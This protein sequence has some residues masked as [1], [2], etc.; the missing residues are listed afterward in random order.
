MNPRIEGIDEAGYFRVQ[1]GIEAAV[2]RG[3]FRSGLEHYLI[4]H[5]QFRSTGMLRGFDETGYLAANPDVAT[6]VARGEMKSGEQ[7]FILHGAAERRAG[8]GL[9]YPFSSRSL[10]GYLGPA[11]NPP[12]PLRVRVSNDADLVQF[13]RLGQIVAFDL[14]SALERHGSLAP[15]AR[16][17]D[18]G[19]GCGRVAQYFQRLYPEAELHGTDIDREAIAWAR[20]TLA[21]V[22]QFASNPPLPP[23]G[24]P[25][26]FFDAIYS[27][28][29]FTHLPEEFE[30][31]WVAE[32]ARV[33]KPGGLLLFTTHGPGLLDA[34]IRSE[35]QERE[36]R[37]KGFTYISGDK[38]AGLPDFYRLSYH[39]RDYIEREWAKHF[40]IVEIVPAGIAKHQDLIVGRKR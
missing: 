9:A 10:P 35:A 39:H 27:V 37:A 4:F 11:I 21:H 18:F 32:L 19:C 40:E 1:P 34:N 17:L 8:S 36:F 2:A 22:G 7:H 23:S 29:V 12:E 38:T 14:S 5:Y 6:A 28:S 25:A 26:D 33:T 20:E 13:H 31:A 16:V 15:G 24:Y 3:D 30:R